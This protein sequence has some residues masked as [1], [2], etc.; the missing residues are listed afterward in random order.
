MSYPKKNSQ[1]RSHQYWII[2]KNSLTGFKISLK[3]K[4]ETNTSTMKFLTNCNI[5]DIG[6]P[7]EYCYYF[8]R[9]KK[10]IIFLRTRKSQN[11]H[12]HLHDFSFWNI[13]FTLCFKFNYIY[14]RAIISYL[15][16]FY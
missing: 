2:I 16:Y 10:F 8:K 11:K 14:F 12:M 6:K 9:I 13:N 3:K 4:Y 1:F 5:H 7:C 15:F